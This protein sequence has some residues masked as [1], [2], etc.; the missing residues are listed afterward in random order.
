MTR[1]CRVWKWKTLDGRAT[2]EDAEDKYYNGT[3][4]DVFRL[5]QFGIQNST[6]VSCLLDYNTAEQILVRPDTM[7]SV[8]NNY[9][10]IRVHIKQT[11]CQQWLQMIYCNYI[12]L[13]SLKSI[14][15]FPPT[16]LPIAHCPSSLSSFPLLVFS[17]IK[18]TCFDRSVDNISFFAFQCI[19]LIQCIEFKYITIH[20]PLHFDRNLQSSQRFVLSVFLPIDNILQ[21][22]S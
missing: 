21:V 16:P 11:V 4:S 6:F 19:V 9:K 5:I 7:I 14:C 3:I 2:E 12:I 10:F 15:H 13:M 1:I 8:N 17:N 20:F 18:I 22:C